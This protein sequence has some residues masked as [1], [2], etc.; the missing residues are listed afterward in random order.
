MN[1]MMRPPVRNENIVK[2]DVVNDVVVEP[3]VE[4]TSPITTTKPS[5]YTKEFT[6]EN[7]ITIKLKDNYYKFQLSETIACSE[8]VDVEDVK[9]NLIN[10]INDKLDEQ[11]A[12]LVAS[13]Q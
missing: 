12:D 13:M 8:G 7:S 6:V 10:K 11:I 1:R 5:Y 3:K 2:E 4:A 9:S